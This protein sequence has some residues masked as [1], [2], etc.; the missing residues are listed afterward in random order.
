M[1][2]AM[3]PSGVPIETHD[4]HGPVH[5]LQRVLARLTRA[6]GGLFRTA[7]TA[8][9]GEAAHI[10]LLVRGPALTRNG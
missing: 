1:I 4:P 8:A 2:A 3:A 5:A 7:R 10:T 6:D 9:H